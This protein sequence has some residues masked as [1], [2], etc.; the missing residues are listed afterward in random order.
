MA[1][2]KEIFTAQP[3]LQNQP[4]HAARIFRVP[5]YQRGYAWGEKQLNQ[6]WQDLEAHLAPRARNQYTGVLTLDRIPRA[7]AYALLGNCDA[8]GAAVIASGHREGFFV[9]DGQQRLTTTLMLL[10]RLSAALGVPN[11]PPDALLVAEQI[12]RDF[13]H[14]SAPNT[15][16]FS[17]QADGVPQPETQLLRQL[18]IDDSPPATADSAYMLNLRKASE[19]LDSKLQR[20]SFEQLIAYAAQV[21]ER[22][23]FQ[24]YELDSQAEKYV[25]FECLNYRGKKLSLLELLKNRM[26]YL[27]SFYLDV[28]GELPSCVNRAWATVYSQ[29]GQLSSGNDLDDLFLRDHWIMRTGRK[30]DEPGA[31]EQSL[32]ESEFRMQRAENGCRPFVASEILDPEELAVHLLRD[33]GSALD[34]RLREAIEQV[35]QSEA[36]DDALAADESDIAVALNQL[37]MDANLPEL[38]GEPRD[39]QI[40]LADQNKKIIK[41]HYAEYLSLGAVKFPDDIRSFCT[42]LELAIKC[43]RT[44]QDPNSQALEI[45]SDEVRRWLW[46]IKMQDNTSARPLL[47][48]T[49][50]MWHNGR[51]G[52]DDTIKVCRMLDRYLLVS[53]TLSNTRNQTIQ[54]FLHREAL[55]LYKSDPEDS[56]DMVSRIVDDLRRQGGS[57]QDLLKPFIEKMLHARTWDMQ[58]SRPGYYGLRGIHYLLWAYED[59][60]RKRRHNDMLIDPRTLVSRGLSSIEHVFPQHPAEGTW[61]E[62]AEY[63]E[64]QKCRLTH[65]LGNLVLLRRERNRSLSNRPYCQKRTR[66][67]DGQAQEICYETGSWSE[68]ELASE[69]PNF[70][71]A[72]AILKRG[73]RLLEFVEGEWGVLLGNRDTKVQLL[74]LDF[75]LEQRSPADRAQVLGEDTRIQDGYNSSGLDGE[76]LVADITVA[77]GEKDMLRGYFTEKSIRTL[78][79][80][81]DD[82]LATRAVPG[83]LKG[84]Q[85]EEVIL[86]FMRNDGAAIAN[87]F[88]RQ[89]NSP[90]PPPDVGCPV[91]SGLGIDVRG[92]TNQ[93]LLDCVK[94]IEAAGMRPSPALPKRIVFRIPKQNVRFNF[95]LKRT[96]A[97]IW[98][99][100]RFPDDVAFWREFVG[101]QAHVRNSGKALTAKVATAEEFA[102][103][104]ATFL[105][106]E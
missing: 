24:Q 69:N 64:A 71:P 14:L 26:L 101:V 47:M 72:E 79:Q 97:T 81:I 76:N 62:Y 9:V 66:V 91:P 37:L 65:S 25:V 41:E 23:V 45:V 59:S 93:D 94:A 42:E 102:A 39:P 85:Y 98:Q 19:F 80:L 100:R 21:S 34:R 48:A 75:M 49:L 35:C 53:R 20:K 86:A 96:W 27:S 83:D 57:S 52:A 16:L 44:I 1:T 89:K 11:A 103:F 12:R 2:L 22:F 51:I 10:A 32:L 46:R 63:N 54:D 17:Y 33:K 77:I 58:A 6:F 87:L 4:G 50:S 28:D 56:Q 104:R 36:G 90:V 78:R 68:Q 38:T 18:F 31:M 99:D 106:A 84:I 61:T 92:I 55:E 60:L 70:W 3:S 29:L 67:L 5:S 8:N 88:V 95:N 73:I 40:A 30:R 82:F 105:H 74:G 7:E 15:L 13:L 43:W